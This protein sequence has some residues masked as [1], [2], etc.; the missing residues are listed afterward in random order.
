MIVPPPSL[1]AASRRA[2]FTL[3][4]LAMAILLSLAI[5]AITMSMI[6]QQVSFHKILR[7]QNFLVEEAPVINNSISH[8]LARA[9]AFRIHENLSDAVSDA[10]AVTVNGKV[11]VVGFSN[12]DSTQDFGIISFEENS[13][14]PF[15]G[16][17]SL[18]AGSSFPGAGSPDWIISRR[19][20]DAVF[21]VDNGVF[22]IQ[23]T[24]PA[25]ETITY[26]GTPRL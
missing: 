20:E 24:G 6:Q 2:G 17:Y 23:L 4:E 21:F 8:I 3:P 18:E 26:T 25:G 5:A 7:A 22:R 19:V 10:N 9:D 16:Y 13:G 14:D 12:P 1:P 11:L 15:L